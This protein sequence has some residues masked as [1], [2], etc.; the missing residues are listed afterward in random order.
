MMIIGHTL[1]WHSQTPRW[2]FEQAN[3]QPATRDTLLARMRTHISAVVGHYKGRIRGWD[4]V[5][6]ALNND[7]TLRQSPWL[8][9]IGE[10]YIAKAFQ[11]A[12]E[13]DPT[14]ELYYNDYDLD[15]A[16]KRQGAVRL[17]KSLLAQG[18]PVAAV[19]LQGHYKLRWP[20]IAEIDSTIRAFSDLGVKV[21][22]TELDVD[23]LPAWKNQPT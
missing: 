15:S 19:G 20:S 17:V 3:G 21:A 18:I 16:S 1:V 12:H 2:V 23:V 22:I 6:E 5:N 13:A 9:I 11:Y 4:V 8:R 7:G 10:D 14:A